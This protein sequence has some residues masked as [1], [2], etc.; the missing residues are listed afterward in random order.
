MNY[1][2]KLLIIISFPLF[3]ILFSCEEN[4]SWVDCKE[5]FPEE[6][7][8]A[9]IEV[10]LTSLQLTHTESTLRIYEGTLET[11]NLLNTYQ[12]YQETFTCYLPV[13]KEYTITY[14][15]FYPGNYYT[16][17]DAV[18]PRVKYDRSSCEEECFFVY[19]TKVNLRL[20]Y[21]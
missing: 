14:S 11:G 12:T 16:I 7:L 13:N 3:T 9:L 2:R 19:D 1:F 8:E 4:G 20:K 6:P 15:F 18:Y 10:K 5:C 21:R 17:V